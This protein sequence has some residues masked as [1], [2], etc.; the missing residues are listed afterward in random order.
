MSGFTKIK[1]DTV[2]IEHFSSSSLIK[3]TFTHEFIT[4]GN[5]DLETSIT[6][7]WFEYGEF[8]DLKKAVNKTDDWL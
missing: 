5:G 7:K 6:D 3:V 4:N 2:K 1:E 8:S